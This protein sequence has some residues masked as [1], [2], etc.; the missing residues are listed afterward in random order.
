MKR[1]YLAAIVFAGS[2]LGAAGV[3]ADATFDVS[4]DTSAI[5][6]T[7]GQVVFELIDGDGTVENFVSL[8]SFDLGG[9]AIG[10]PADYLGSSGVSG[11]LSGTI[12]MDDS[13]ASAFFTQ[14]V[15]F[16]TSLVFRLST[17]NAPGVTPDAFS[18]ALYTPDFSACYSDDSIGCTLLRLDLVGGTL[19]PASFALNGASAQE[20]P[21]PVVTLASVPEP[22]SL[23][24]L[25]AGLFGLAST[26]SSRPS[27]SR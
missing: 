1:H 14:L 2:M 22:A 10:A 3:R 11:D 21:A 17:T 13:G 6:G 8:S 24:L 20:L 23:L 25:A 27:R 12:A 4:L 9:G 26:R 5:S 7:D 15:N 16:G 19:S 18:M